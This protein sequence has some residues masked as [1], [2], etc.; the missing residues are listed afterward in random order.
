M[1]DLNKDH[2]R[3][4]SRHSIPGADKSVE[5]GILKLNRVHTPLNQRKQIFEQFSEDYL[6]ASMTNRVIEEH[7]RY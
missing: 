7:K 6:I 3:A 2:D 4:L 5:G 1:P